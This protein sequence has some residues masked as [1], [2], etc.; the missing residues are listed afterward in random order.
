MFFVRRTRVL[1]CFELLFVISFQQKKNTRSCVGTVLKM[2]FTLEGASERLLL[3]LFAALMTTAFPAYFSCNCTAVAAIQGPK[4][5]GLYV[6][7]L[8]IS[9]CVDCFANLK[10]SHSVVD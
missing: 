2:D 10:I 8:V 7:M 9:I 4:L 5:N 1:S 6:Q 3:F